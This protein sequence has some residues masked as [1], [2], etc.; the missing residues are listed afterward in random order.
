MKKILCI[1]EALIDM[2]CIDKNHTL[3][4]GVNFLKKAGGA[5]TNV[6]ATIATLGGK[7]DLFAKVG[8]DPFGTHLIETM[9]DFGVCTDFIFKDVSTFTTLAFVSLMENGE[10]DFYFNRGADAFLNVTDLDAIQLNNYDIIHFGSATAFLSGQLQETYLELLRKAIATRKFICF[11]PNYRD[12]LFRNNNEKFIHQSWHFMKYAN[13]MKVSEE[14]AL[15]LTQTSKIEEA[16]NILQNSI[17]GSFAI[18][19]G[20]QGA[21]FGNAS[22]LQTIPS[23]TINSVDTTGAGDAF[24][25]TVLYQLANAVHFQEKSDDDWLKIIQNANIVGAKTCEYYG[26][27]EALKYISTN[28]FA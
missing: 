18:T 5:P 1:G 15:M 17:N 7:V 12:L 14:E 27:M 13:F 8:N 23:I 25:G 10:R 4:N 16:C 28:I 22:F 19:I 2:V 6:A 24:V 9:K 26:A 3:N 21:I 11:D 20:Q